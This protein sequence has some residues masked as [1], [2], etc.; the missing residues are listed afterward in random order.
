VAGVWVVAVPEE[1]KRKQHYL[2]KSITTDQYGHFDLHGLAPGKYNLF[3]WDGVEQGEWED[4]DFLKDS[5]E[6]GVTVDLKGSDTKAIEL[7]LIQVKSRPRRQSGIVAE[8]LVANEGNKF[9]R[10]GVATT[11]ARRG[12]PQ[13]EYLEYCWRP[14]STNRSNRSSFASRLR[15]AVQEKGTTMFKTSRVLARVVHVQFRKD[16]SRGLGQL[17]VR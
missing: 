2:F 15:R 17:S 16:A 3:S 14:W 6:K 11:C 8:L 1:P 13:M 9:I 10:R 5:E 12:C 7:K 4:T